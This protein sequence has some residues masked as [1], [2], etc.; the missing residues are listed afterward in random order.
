M[1]APSWTSTAATTDNFDLGP[2]F[3]GDDAIVLFLAD[4]TGPLGEATGDGTDA[5]IHDV[6]GVPGVDGSGT[7]WEYADSFA[8]RNTTSASAVFNVA[9]WTVPGP[10]QLESGC[11]GDDTCETMNLQTM[12]DPTP[13]G[14]CFS[15]VFTD[16][17]N[18]DGGTDIGAGNICTPCPCGNDATPAR[19]GLPEQRRDLRA[20]AGDRQ[21]EPP[22]QDL[23]FEM[24]GGKPDSFAVLTSGNAIAPANMANACFGL[25]SGI[26]A[27]SLDGLRCAVQGVLRHGSRAIDSVGYV[28]QNG[29]PPEGRWGYCAPNFPNADLF[30]AGQTKHFQSIYREDAG[31]V[32]STEQNTSQAVSVTFVP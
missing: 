32:C 9:D 30:A 29:T 26:Q 1:R 13:T 12:T 28:G 16:S 18:G 7:A 4:G 10:D 20:A 15:G 27:V 21:P 11:S 17:C 24:E 6:Y 23:C 14:G 19:S 22:G 5:T 31:V 3:N 8:Q 2:F 25:N